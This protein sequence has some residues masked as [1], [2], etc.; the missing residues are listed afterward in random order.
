MR[1]LRECS[2]IL[3]SGLL[4]LT[5]SS[6]ASADGVMIAQPIPA[7][8][9][10]PQPFSVKY[11]HV[12]V[13][14]ENQAATTVIDQVFLNNND[15]EIE[16]MY[17]FPIPDGASITEFAMW[18]NGEKVT[19]ELLDAREA[20]RIYWETVQRLKDPGLLEYAG[21]D[22]YR[23][24]VYPIPPR[25][26]VRIE[27]SYH[28]VLDYEAGVVTYRYP[29]DTERFSHEPIEDV[30]IAVEIES[31]TPIKSLYSPSHDVD[32]VV[33]GLSASCGYE[34]R[35]AKPDR[36]FFLYYTVSEQDLG[37][38]LIAHRE[39]R[40]DGYFLLLLSPGRIEDPGRIAPKD[41][42]FVIDRSG[43]MKGQKIEQA[44]AALVYSLENLSPGDRFNVITF[45]TQVR[46]F[47]DELV[48]AT[49]DN[50]ADALEF[51]SKIEAAGST[52][53][54]EALW[55]ALGGRDSGRTR[56]LV[57]L[58]DG[59]PT[60]GEQD[61]ATILESV[62]KRNGARARIFPFGVGYDVNTT[63]LDQ[64]ALDNRGTIEYVKPDE[65]IEEKVTSFYNKV[66]MPIL[67]DI[68]IAIEG[69]E[70]YDTYPVDLPDI[71]NGTQAVV[72]GRYAG[73]GASEITLRGTVRGHE[74][75]FEYRAAFPERTQEHDFIPP[76]W[77]ARKIAYL[78]TEIRLHGEKEE[79]KDEIVDLATRYGIVTPYTSYLVREDIGD[80]LAFEPNG[81]PRITSVTDAIATGTTVRRGPRP[82]MVEI[83]ASRPLSPEAMRAQ[84][85]E[86]GV[87]M[88]SQLADE[89]NEER[90]EAPVDAAVR[91][92]GSKIFFYDTEFGGWVD[93][94][95]ATWTTEI[96]EIVYMSDDYRALFDR[97]PDVGRYLA[98]GERVK[99]VH[100]DTAYAVEPARG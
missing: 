41:I 28:E 33:S 22:M 69:V 51:V 90:I 5:A 87:N 94:E 4:I 21:R 68:S 75:V 35:D 27:M 88:S 38:N 72:L 95:I 53:I 80:H 23:A 25:G 24:Y 91:R 34:D 96:I 36:D 89:R 73:S 79:L 17:V 54:D 66:S 93:Q 2:I 67:S 100:D 61:V 57:F 70:V 7:L 31:N 6:I 98:L 42:V 81:S 48:S 15:R 60:V 99:F 37:L 20:R 55:E 78:M 49:P 3:I 29:L 12:D 50:V 10:R 39:A 45:A 14:I 77:A 9:E 58:T 1:P 52:N 13:T 44:K 32:A 92:V 86:A 40:E 19:G 8:L 47:G 43:S 59:L 65:S 56:M 74:E 62:E 97:S 83:K 64:L 16:G 11:H 76:V 30:S 46:A 71:F 85:G 26:E 84:G 18:M 63:F 82:G